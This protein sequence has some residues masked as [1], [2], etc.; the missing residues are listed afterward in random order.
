MNIRFLRSFLPCLAIAAL[1]APLAA[2]AQDSAADQPQIKPVAVVSLA[3][4]KEIQ[5][6]LTFL[7]ASAD[8]A[9]LGNIANLMIA[10][11]SRG[12]DVTKPSG[13]YAT[14]EGAEPQAVGFVPVTDF[15][16]IRTQIEDRLGEVE[17]AGNGILRID[18]PER[19]LYLKPQDGW[20]YISNTAGSLAG[21]PKD[22]SR[23]LNGLAQQYDVAMQINMRNV[24]AEVRDMIVTQMKSGFEQGFNQSFQGDEEDRELAES[25]GRNAIDSYVSLIQDS[26]QITLGWAIDKE[27]KT[28]YLDFSLTA[29]AGTKLA[30]QMAL[31]QDTK[32]AFTGFQMPKSAMNMV[33]SS[34]MG[35]KEIEQATTMLKAVRER[36]MKQI[37][38]DADLP[39]DKARDAV[40]EVLGQLMDVATATVQ[41]GKID[42]GA[43]LLL[44]AGGLKFAAGGHVADGPALEAAFRKLVDIARDEPEFPQVNFDVEKYNG[45][46]FHTMSVPV[47]G[48][49]PE[50]QRVLGEN[51][52]VAL[53][54]GAEQF[55]MALG[56][57][58]LN[59]VKQVIDGSKSDQGKVVPP[60]Q[61]TLSL[62][63]ILE[64]AN[65]MEENPM[66]AMLTTTVKAAGGRDHIQLTAKSIDRGVTYR[67]NVEDG[68]LKLIGQA[69]KIVSGQQQDFG[70]DF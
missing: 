13:M 60:M 25:L 69:V 59:L 4:L 45:I 50:A 7:T 41:G 63:P 65:A 6:D 1:L 34:K 62:A 22:P 23:L 36:A 16:S 48:D 9:D 38:E 19:A 10:Q 66:I 64:F 18:L 33:L 47:P 49:E 39:D 3:S 5:D 35:Q 2:R 52:D 17:D 61:M 37:E 51:L 15:E 29:V 68:V 32:S 67:L 14:M 27:A 53:G 54:I 21:V 57:D 44:E 11:F 24:P 43:V 58:S 46:T 31:M 30:Q 8:I 56:R 42:G 12:I 55:Y 20:V 28:T 26:E 40:K 70:D